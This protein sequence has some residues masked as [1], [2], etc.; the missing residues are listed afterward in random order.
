VER[1]E[2]WEEWEGVDR[3]MRG[4]STTNPKDAAPR[5]ML[6]NKKQKGEEGEKES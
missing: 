2:E 3:F 6:Q 5:I 4:Y 1:R